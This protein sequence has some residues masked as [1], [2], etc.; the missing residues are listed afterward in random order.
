ML[1]KI[2]DGK[3]IANK[4]QQ[5]LK[6]EIAIFTKDY[7]QPR[8]AVILVGD[9]PASEIYVRKK[10]EACV[11]VGI[12]SI[13]IKEIANHNQ[14]INRLNDLNDD[15]NIH[16]ILVQLPLPKDH[17]QEDKLFE[18][19][20][21][22]SPLKD[23]DV[24]NPENFGLLVQGR[25]RFLPCT[26]HGIQLMLKHSDLQVKGKHV[27]VISRS[28]VVGKPLSSM[29]IQDNDEF[30]NATVT[31]CHDNTPFE[32]LANITRTADVIIVAVGIPG[33][34]KEDMIKSGAVVIDVG[35]SRVNNK[36]VGDVDQ[37][38]WNV[39]GY[40]SPVPGG[41]G[42]LTISCLLENTFKAAKLQINK[43]PI[44]QIPWLVNR[45]QCI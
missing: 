24:F 20:S 35:I 21:T 3:S 8:L 15:V 10:R 2:I 13:L 32:Q 23:V 14:L 29:L 33:F 11:F 12:D 44:I 16:G 4:L 30:A 25:P 36:V 22:I 43:K 37:S 34:L 7:F 17:W 5:S 6:D 40:C 18:I 26:P 1:A 27:V 38:V 41:C 42:P 31:V 19:F 45:W 28:F 9:D 39:A